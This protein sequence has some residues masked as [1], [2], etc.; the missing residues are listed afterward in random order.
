MAATSARTMPWQWLTVYL[1]VTT[2]VTSCG[3]AD[4]TLF[5]NNLTDSAGNTAGADSVINWAPIPSGSSYN[6]SGSSYDANGMETL[7]DM[8]NTFVGL[9]LFPSEYPTGLL[10]FSSLA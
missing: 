4:P 2:Y 10:Y 9:C 5:A 8:A 6:S 7:Y 1:F 3:C